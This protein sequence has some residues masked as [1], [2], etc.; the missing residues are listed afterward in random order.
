[1][2]EPTTPAPAAFGASE[3]HRPRFSPAELARLL[4]RPEPTTE[5]AQVIA[6]PLEPGV[7]IA[8]AGSGK[9]ETMASRVVWLVA[10]GHV[11]PEQ[12]LGLTFTRKATAE[13]AERVR[14][15]LEQLRATEQ[16]PDELLDGEPTVSTYNSY[17]GRIVGDHALREAVE[18]TSRLLS[19]GQAWQLAARIVGEYDGPMDHVNVGAD[20]VTRRVLD[21]SGQISDHLT[22]TDQVRGVGRWIQAGVDAMSRKPTQPTRDLV[23]TQRRRE[24]LLPLVERYN[25]AKHT[26]EA[27]D[28]GDQM[29]LAAR[30]AQNHPEVGLIER[31]R[32]RVVL[33]DEYQDTSHAQLVLLRALFGDGH[34]V[35]AVGD[36]CQSIYGW[37]GAIAANLTSFPTDFPIAPGR[38]AS[39]RRLSLSF[40]NGEKVLNVAERIS[41]PLRAE[42]A[43]V[44][45]LHPGPARRGRG[46]ALTALFST[47]TEEAAW[48]AQQVRALVEATAEEAGGPVFAP[49]GKAWPEGES[50]GGQEG[51]ISPG[52]IAVLCRKRS[53]FP[54]LREALEAQ[55]IP[56]EVVGLGGLM[57]VPEVRDIIATL[58]VVHDASAGNELAR[59]LTGP[60]WR[61]GPRDL[62]ALGKRASELARHTRRDLTGP[63]AEESAEGEES[64]DLLRRTVL[65]LT[66]ES[67]SLV[68]AVDD[69]GDAANYSATAY[70]R[71]GR[72]SEELRT[73]RK[74][75]GQPLPDLITEIERMLGLDI[76][77][78]ARIHRDPLSARADLDA[79]VDHAV[80]FVGNTEDP[81]LGSFLGYLNAAEENESALS[82]G[83]RVGG[84]DS[85][86]LMTMHGA[87]GLEWPVVIVPGVSAGKRAPL[88]PAK[89]RDSLAW[90]KADHL[91]P[92]PLR[93]DRSS[94]PALRGVEKDDIAAFKEAE[95]AR[96]L[97]EE[98]RLAYVAVTRASYALVCTGHW[99]GR[100]GSTPR[101][102]SEFLEEIRAACER[103]AGSVVRWDPPPDPE[104]T[105]PHDEQ[106]SSAVWPPQEP[107]AEAEEP[108]PSSV[109]VVSDPVPDFE[110]GPEPDFEYEP[111]YDPEFDDVPPV[112]EY[113]PVPEPEP[114][115]APARTVSEPPEDSRRAQI[116]AG[117]DLVENARA[118]IREGRPAGPR[119]TPEGLRRRLQG[120]ERDTELLLAHR[121]RATTG[122]GEGP[123]QVELPDH[124]SVSSMVWLARDPSALARQ[125]R[126][127][128]P[129]PPAPHTRRGTAFHT[130]LE[131]RFGQNATL[132][133]ELPG[134][135]DETAGEDEDLAELQRRFEESEWGPRIPSE[136]EVPF[137]TV[138]GDRLIRGRM[139][140]VFHDADTGRYDVVDWK[141]GRPPG[142]QVERR[143][144]SVQL[145]AYRLAWADL[146]GVE[147]EEV[148]A[149]FHYVR[150]GETVR[151]ADLL[152]AEGLAALITNVP[153]P[154]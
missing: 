43:D 10:N 90:V 49:D 122:P 68:D 152:D 33:L 127:P 84:S 87:K 23:D 20:T 22:T 46:T 11:R 128:L 76:E 114:G 110:F 57:L 38:P 34:A 65:D 144:V 60:R 142:N 55:D 77:V 107:Q 113:E 132:L 85:V 44:P 74:F 62:A 130:W 18:P 9:S 106:E 149:A 72:L 66:A 64:E 59:L 99:W 118:R 29:A 121:D 98:R 148:R 32:F 79:F 141:T 125:I 35:T 8:G 2:S 81:T 63:A 136:V 30:I 145:A 97:M 58:R 117:A 115:P 147:L 150:A 134:A 75:V 26:R 140:A 14:K 133:D 93:G 126:R 47:E 53:Q 5:Q 100:T 101:G 154:T 40:R 15:R 88:F 109:P 153:E 67:G 1:M 89:A 45:V 78:A 80:R 71:L 54:P 61:M 120:W 103:G 129:R 12:V 143:A 21:L 7:V 137:E 151:P 51:R 124:L 91:L 146:A 69:P 139:D 82:P 4:K 83:E 36:P 42:A 108:D 131:Q 119:K 135:A 92:Y 104:D 31:G 73:L 27:M 6:A 24:E 50:G 16:L 37:R 96:H 41:E 111:E 52:D 3:E 28:F 102:P 39:V 112:P 123:V 48:I 105:N 19:E 116:L 138:I 94:L 13:L 95:E 25:H 17:A 70:E 86:K 56:V